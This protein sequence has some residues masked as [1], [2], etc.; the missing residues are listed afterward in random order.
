M[1]SKEK[2]VYGTS[3]CG[4][5]VKVYTMQ[6]NNGSSVELCN[7][8]ATILSVK[9]PDKEGKIEDVALGFNDYETLMLDGACV[10]RSVG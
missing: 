8:G 10:G 1:E 6:A 2:C 3:K 7:L 4:K 9:V 5:E